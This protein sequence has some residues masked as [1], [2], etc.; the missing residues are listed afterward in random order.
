MSLKEIKQIKIPKETAIPTGT[1][2]ITLDV[3]SPKYST[4]DFYIKNANNGRVPRLLKVPGYEGVLIHCGN[5][6]KDSCGCIL[7]GKNT[8][9]GMVTDS[10][11]TFIKLYKIL[12]SAKDEITITIQ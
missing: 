7:V 1:Y 2:K 8:K 4:K 12:Q 6:A 5:T 9:V 3:I 10:K 11:V